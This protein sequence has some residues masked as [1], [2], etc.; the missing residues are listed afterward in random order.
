MI[1]CFLSVQVQL[2]SKIRNNP[3]ILQGFLQNIH[4]KV[5]IDDEKKVFYLI[6]NPALYPKWSK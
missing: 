3:W 4:R 5:L 2:H 1:D 6:K